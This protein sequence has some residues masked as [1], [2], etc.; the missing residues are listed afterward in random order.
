M[1]PHLLQLQAIRGLDILAKNLL[2]KAILDTAIVIVGA[3]IFAKDITALQFGTN[4]RCARQCQ[5]D[6]L[7]ITLEESRQEG[8][9]RIIVTMGFIEEIDTLDVHGILLHIHLAIAVFQLLDIHHDDLLLPGIALLGCGGLKGLHQFIACLHID[10][11][12]TSIR[13]LV[14]GLLHQVQTIHE[15]IEFG[16]DIQAL[17]VVRQY[18]GGKITQS[19]LA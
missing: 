11:F 19:C 3:D 9:L 16:Y 8:A 1:V 6:C 15:E 2:R 7:G 14:G 18:T 5:T 12:Q 13:E 10:N 17:V 4:E